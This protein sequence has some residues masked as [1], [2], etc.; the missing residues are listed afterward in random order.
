MFY[1][2]YHDSTDTGR[3]HGC[4]TTFG[5][6]VE[7]GAP[8]LPPNHR[9]AY[10]LY[11]LDHYSKLMESIPDSFYLDELKKQMEGIR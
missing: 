6:G 7:L 4:T 2:L 5:V 3:V 1:R 9:W 11:F 10:S 8:M